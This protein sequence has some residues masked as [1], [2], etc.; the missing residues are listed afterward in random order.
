ML[1]QYASAIGVLLAVC[2]LMNHVTAQRV[3]KAP[4]RP[5]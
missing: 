3:R 4:E 2:Q 5:L 1:H